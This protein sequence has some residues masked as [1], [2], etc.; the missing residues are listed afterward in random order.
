M[1]WSH[2]RQS[3]QTGLKIDFSRFYEY[4][5]LQDR[6]FPNFDYHTIE[7]GIDPKRLHA[8]HSENLVG[9]QQRAFNIYWGIKQCGLTGYVG[10]D[11]G[12][13]GIQAPFCL[14][15]DKYSGESPLY[16]G[17]LNPQMKCSAEDTSLFG[18]EAFNLIVMNH[19][20]EHVEGDVANFINNDWFRILKPNGILA[21]IVPDGQ[22]NSV[23][24]MDKDHKHCWIP[25]RNSKIPEFWKYQIFEDE[26][27]DK[28]KE[29]YCVYEFDTLDNG[30]SFDCVLRKRGTDKLLITKT[31]VQR[32][33]YLEEKD[34]NECDHLNSADA[35]KKYYLEVRIDDFFNVEDS[36][37]KFLI[38]SAKT[39]ALTGA[40]VGIICRNNDE[41]NI[42]VKFI[43]EK[44]G[45][46]NNAEIEKGTKNLIYGVER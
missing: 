44:F 38:D 28:V 39:S 10:L 42:A 6:F 21:I 43:S 26:V 11:I 37:K 24:Q 35:E 15:T 16:G 29:K 22:Y 30:F 23:Y 3:K 40:Q 20:L 36:L 17:S 33:A 41:V 2:D 34:W 13:A 32:F 46:A 27:L 12:S 8:S 31:G 1:N 25:R 7:R 14:G 18:N 4:A 45:T 5:F 19:S 9:N